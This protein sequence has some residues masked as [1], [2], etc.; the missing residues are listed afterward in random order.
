MLRVCPR[1]RQAPGRA[2]LTPRGAGGCGGK[3]GAALP[4]RPPRGSTQVHGR[5][6]PAQFSDPGMEE[7]RRDPRTP[8]S[9]L[10]PPATGSREKGCGAARRGG[11]RGGAGRG[12][13]GEGSPH[14]L[15]THPLPRSPPG[16]APRSSP[17]ASPPDAPRPAR[18]RAAGANRRERRVCERAE[19]KG[20]GRVGRSLSPPGPPQTRVPPAL[21]SRGSCGPSHH[22]RLLCRPLEE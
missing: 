7:V 22:T 16:R 9:S 17:R 21:L 19:P 8:A 2:M 12:T 6:P 3:L 13:V 15:F 18:A 20:V 5:A 11:G 4:V 1:R 10:P 14:G